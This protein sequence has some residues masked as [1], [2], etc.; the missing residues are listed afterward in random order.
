M[1][2]LPT[3]QDVVDDPNQATPDKPRDPLADM[4]TCLIPALIAA[5]PAFIDA[6]FRCISEGNGGNSGYTPGDRKRCS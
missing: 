2:T 4:M 3:M 1:A 6:F 5:L